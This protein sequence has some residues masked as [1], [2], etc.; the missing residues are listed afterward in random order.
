MAVLVP[1]CAEAVGAAAIAVR[2]SEPPAR[3]AE[4]T[5]PAA[6]WLIEV[7]GMTI[8]PAQASMSPL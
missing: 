5:A 1:A 6:T 3:A 4:I 7:F 8:L 2:L